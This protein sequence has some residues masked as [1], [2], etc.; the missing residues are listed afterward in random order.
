MKNQARKLES[1]DLEIEIHMFELDEEKIKNGREFNFIRKIH[2][3]NYTYNRK[4]V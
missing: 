2:T 4:K 3:K 1:Y